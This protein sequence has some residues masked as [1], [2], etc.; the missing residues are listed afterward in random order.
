MSYL[1]ILVLTCR[2]S[3]LID[4]ENAA[5]RNIFLESRSYYSFLL[6]EFEQNDSHRNL[7]RRSSSATHKEKWKRGGGLFVQRINSSSSG[8]SLNIQQEDKDEEAPDWELSEIALSRRRSLRGDPKTIFSKAQV[9]WD[10]YEMKSRECRRVA[11]TADQEDLRYAAL[12][13]LQA[14]RTP[15]CSITRARTRKAVI[16]FVDVE[17]KKICTPLEDTDAEVNKQKLAQEEEL[18]RMMTAFVAETSRKKQVALDDSNADEQGHI[19]K[20]E[21]VWRAHVIMEERATRNKLV[22]D[23]SYASI[24][25]DDTMRVC[26]WDRHCYEAELQH[27]QELRESVNKN[28]LHKR[29][30]E[31]QGHYR[32]IAAAQN[33]SVIF[34]RKLKL[35]R[36]QLQ[37]LE[38]A[39]RMEI[40]AECDVEFGTSI[41]LPNFLDLKAA[42]VSEEANR[43]MVLEGFQVY[44]FSHRFRSVL[45]YQK[46]FEQLLV[47]LEIQYHAAFETASTEAAQE[48]EFA[49]RQLVLEDETLERRYAARRQQDVEEKEK[50][51]MELVYGVTPVPLLRRQGSATLSLLSIGDEAEVLAKRHPMSEIS[52][53]LRRLVSTG[54]RDKENNRLFAMLP[55][56][57][58]KIFPP[59][60]WTSRDVARDTVLLE[61]GMDSKHD[62]A[63]GLVS[64]RDGVPQTTMTER[65]R[66]YSSPP[67]AYRRINRQ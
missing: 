53:V 1:Q 47:A 32:D 55:S 38:Q 67:N 18:T 22:A 33:A 64:R 13:T 9:D 19:R 44:E 39:N 57:S 66:N 4:E 61:E 36:D 27:R 40:R 25:G 6:Q 26:T 35:A 8:G 15:T 5:R 24:H 62:A 46:R 56:S 52:N 43:R 37:A 45:I 63:A 28:R 7:K 58:K 59:E 2:S 21:G 23:F 42:M 3:T 12:D 31:V 50:Y 30:L 48:I 41:F 20:G 51:K 10:M 34:K 49:G 16:H 65:H 60:G 11:A 14:L 17:D 54:A 29:F